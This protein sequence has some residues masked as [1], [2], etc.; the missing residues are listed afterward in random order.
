MRT[1]TL[2][3]ALVLLLAFTLACGPLAFLNPAQPTAT[4][5]PAATATKPAAGPTATQPA[6]TAPTAAP[7]KAGAAPTAAPTKP[8][9]QPTTATG[10]DFFSLWSNVQ[11][12]T[13]SATKYRMSMSMIIGSTEN[14]VYKETPFLVSEGWTVGKDSYQAFTGGMLNDLLGGTKIEMIQAGGTSY[15]KGGAMF[16]LMD[17][18]KWYSMSDSTSLS[19]PIDPSD[20]LGMSGLDSAT[21]A[22]SAK[23][24]GTETLDGQSCDVW[25]W[26][27]AQ[28]TPF[29]GLLANPTQATDLSVTDKSEVRSWIC[30]DNYVHKVMME[31]AGHSKDNVNEKGAM[32]FDI[33]IWDFDNPTLSVT[34]PV[35]ALPFG[36]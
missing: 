18:T 26:S 9:A 35:G 29:L 30:R 15:M 31:I 33:H 16:G 28:T 34:A 22:T 32:K 19:P 13:A 17:P 8:A 11:G 10:G 27:I 36:N 24:T 7:T 12:R 4:P 2:F 23:K 14:G 21:T 3:L 20:M 25:V 1:K 5:A 6:A